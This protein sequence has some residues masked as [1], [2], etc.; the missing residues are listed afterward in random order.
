MFVPLW[1]SFVGQLANSMFF[2]LRNLFQFRAAKH[3]WTGTNHSCTRLFCTKMY[4]YILAQ[5]CTPS[6]I[7]EQSG[8][9]RKRVVDLWGGICNFNFKLRE[10]GS[11]C[12]FEVNPRARAPR[13]QC[14]DFISMYI[15]VLHIQ[16]PTLGQNHMAIHWLSMNCIISDISELFQS[17]STIPSA[18]VPETVR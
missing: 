7:W 2:W 12:I 4:L 1:D 15:D 6:C 8:W 18:R 14:V 5:S 13:W 17:Y 16:S 3:S 9:T 10:D 11:M